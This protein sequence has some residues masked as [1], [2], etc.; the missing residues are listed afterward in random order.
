M[1]KLPL[2]FYQRDNVLLI[3]KELLGKILVTRWNG[4]ITSGRIVECEAYD[5][6]IDQ[7]S[8][9]F[10]GRRT[11]RNEIMYADAGTAYVYICYGIHHLFNVV[12]NKNDI[13]H[14]ILIRAVEPLQGTK[15]MLKRRGK[16]QMNNTLTKGPGSLSGALGIHIS[17]NGFSLHHRELFIADDGFVPVKKDIGRSERIGVE[18]AGKAAKY[19]YR[20]YIKGN[21]F[22]SGRP[23]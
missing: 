11:A 14:A 7:A 5:G 3:A 23:R 17:H 18:S 20:F 19:L 1:K 15:E 2:S 6:V 10:R 8:H 22:V 12:T 9:A 21:P 16:K 4:M 13:P